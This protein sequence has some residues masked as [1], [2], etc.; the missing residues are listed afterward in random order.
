VGKRHPNLSLKLFDLPAVADRAKL[1]FERA[2]FS[3]RAQTFGGDFTSTPLPQGADVA[4]LVRVLL[5]HDDAR[6]SSILQNV[7][8]A[9]APGAMLVMAEPIGGLAGAETV[10]DAYFG[11]YLLAMGKGRARSFQELKEL[12]EAQGF[13][14]VAQ[15]TTRRPLMT[16]LLTAV[17][18]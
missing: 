1:R 7:H 3:D 17:R 12:L 14:S 6:V 10:G 2:G 15:K 16:G 8:A 13:T 4:T 9:L 18:A 5:D 11:F